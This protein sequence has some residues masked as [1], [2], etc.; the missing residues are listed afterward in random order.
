MKRFALASVMALAVAVPAQAVETDVVLSGTFAG[1]VSYSD[2]DTVGSDLD[3]DNNGS[4]IGLFASAQEQGIRA[5]VNYERGFDRYSPTSTNTEDRDFVREFFGGVTH[6]DYGTLSLGRMS[7]AYKRAGMR[8][9]PF[10]D[11]SLSGFNG[12]LSNEGASFGLSNLTNGFTSNTLA[13]A[14]PAFGNWSG[15]A[16]LYANDNGSNQGDDD[17]DFGVGG[18]YEDLDGGWQAGAQYLDV[19]GNVVFG[20]P[21]PGGQ[22]L[23]V[24][25]SYGVETWSLGASAEIVD[26][27]GGDKREYL[28]LS[29]TYQWSEKIQLAA[30]VGSTKDTPF[31]GEAITAGA[32][33]E[34]FKNFNTYAGVRFATL[35]AEDTLAIATGLRYSFEVDLD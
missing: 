25:G 10:Y 2:S 33:Y 20:F 32:F 28:F 22:A 11:T 7:T 4:N 23:R 1:S 26:I 8:V 9:D 35:D 19:N 31:D 29:G 30:A 14:S 16:A 5:F 27:D 34:V 6:A 15:N 13:Y 18:T 24:H 12:L 3:V 17:N 21:V